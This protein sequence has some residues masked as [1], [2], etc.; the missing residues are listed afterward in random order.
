MAFT[1]SVIALHHKISTQCRYKNNLFPL[2]S[3]YCIFSRLYRSEVAQGLQI[4]VQSEYNPEY[5][6]RRV[7]LFLKSVKVPLKK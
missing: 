1:F 7:E 6:D 4:T 5:V 3:G 2:F